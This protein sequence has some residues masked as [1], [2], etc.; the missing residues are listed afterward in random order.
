LPDVVA[1]AAG[2][3][4]KLAAGL[5]AAAGADVAALPLDAGSDKALAP[6][7]ERGFGVAPPSVNLGAPDAGA[8]EAAPL[9]LNKLG[10]PAGAADGAP[11]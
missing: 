8:D 10:A 2:A 7:V 4:N 3:P 11:D 1:E 5:L 9:G 6:V